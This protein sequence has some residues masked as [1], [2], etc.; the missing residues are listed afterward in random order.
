LGLTAEEATGPPFE[1]WP[2]NWPA[3]NIYCAMRT[4]WNVGPAGPVGL[5]YASLGEV[6]RRLKVPPS[7]RDQAFQDLQVMEAAALNHMHREKT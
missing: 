5:N 1:V 2:D 4:Q 7:D 6:W 3:I